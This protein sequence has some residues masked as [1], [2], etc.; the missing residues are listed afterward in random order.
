M[1]FGEFWV[2]FLFT[3]FLGFWVDFGHFRVLSCVIGGFWGVLGSFSG[4]FGY[5]R[6]FMLGFGF[7]VLMFGFEFWV[8]KR[9]FGFGFIWFGRM[10]FLLRLLAAGCV[11]G[12]AFVCFRI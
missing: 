7:R 11:L 1:F 5:F 10:W 6:C 12:W 9:G 2:F 3:C 8:S 4:I